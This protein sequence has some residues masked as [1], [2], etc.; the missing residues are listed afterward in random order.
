MN[1]F[2]TLLWLLFALPCAAGI[3]VLAAQFLDDSQ[4]KGFIGA[5][6]AMVKFALLMLVVAALFGSGIG[7]FHD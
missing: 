2:Q 1:V 3:G 4:E 7:F 5:V 6:A